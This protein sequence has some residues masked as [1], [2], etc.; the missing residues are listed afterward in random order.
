MHP[1]KFYSN[2]NSN[3]NSNSIDNNNHQQQQQPLLY[4][5]PDHKFEWTREEFQLFCNSI[6]EKYGYKVEYSGI[7]D[8][9]SIQDREGIGYCSQMAVFLRDD[10][11]ST[12]D[13][14][15]VS[16]IYAWV[17]SILNISSTLSLI[18]LSKLC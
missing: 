15:K 12:S 11:N 8:P 5:H 2:N 1:L 6:A 4:R 7:G 10:S 14:A 16:I 9:P 17:I 13:S 3:N 18:I